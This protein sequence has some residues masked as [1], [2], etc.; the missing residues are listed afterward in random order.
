[1][2]VTTDKERPVL[3]KCD[4]NHVLMY[5]CGAEDYLDTCAQC[6]QQKIVKLACNYCE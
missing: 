1:M 3:L 6:Q 2:R 4:K 5:I